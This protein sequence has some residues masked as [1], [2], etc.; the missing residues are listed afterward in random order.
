[1]CREKSSDLNRKLRCVFVIMG[2]IVLM[3]VAN[4]TPLQRNKQPVGPESSHLVI[5]STD[6]VTGHRT[7]GPDFVTKIDTHTLPI[8]V[9]LTMWVENCNGEYS[10]SK[11][12]ASY[13]VRGR[14]ASE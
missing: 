6:P 8:P 4:A 11:G 9:P 5:E 10:Y 13:S 1:M 14:F 12:E 2:I 7:K 3:A